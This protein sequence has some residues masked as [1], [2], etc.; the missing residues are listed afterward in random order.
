MKSSLSEPIVLIT[1]LQPFLI[2]WVLTVCFFVSLALAAIL[3]RGRRWYEVGCIFFLMF[4]ISG[5][6]GIVVTS[7]IVDVKMIDIEVISYQNF[8]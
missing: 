8:N 3:S 5:I 6:L 7:L 1:H 4:V 2:L